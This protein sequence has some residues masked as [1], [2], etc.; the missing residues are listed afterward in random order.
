MVKAD[1]IFGIGY[2]IVKQKANEC[3]ERTGD[4]MNKKEKIH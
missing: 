4:F 3:S 2:D 1:L